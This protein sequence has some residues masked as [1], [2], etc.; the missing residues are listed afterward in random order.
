MK[1]FLAVLG[2]A[3]MF[4]AC[5]NLDLLDDLP[6]DVKDAMIEIEEKDA[7]DFEPLGGAETFTIITSS[8]NNWQVSCKEDWVTLGG[9]V[10]GSGNGTVSFQVS[11][12]NGKQ[13][14]GTIY[15]NGDT[16]TRH[17][18]RTISISQKGEK[19]DSENE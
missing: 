12:N 9:T 2:L 15:V 13:R 11:Y 17:S 18:L 6:Q 8:V 1:K 10:S 7:F 3:L 16:G 19:S 4:T 5:K 14:R